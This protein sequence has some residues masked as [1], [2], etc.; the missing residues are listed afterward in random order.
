M[1]IIIGARGT[2]Q[3]GWDPLERLQLDMRNR[4]D[5]EKLFA[6]DSLE[7][8]LS[9]HVL[10]HLT[11]DDAQG[12]ARNI[13]AFLAPGGFWRIAVPDANNPDPVYQ[14]FCRPNGSE[15]RKAEFWTGLLTRIAECP[16]E[17]GHKAHYNLKSISSLLSSVGF[18]VKPLEFYDEAG[19][20]W[21]APWDEQ[22]GWIKRSSKSGFLLMDRVLFGLW[23][24][25]LIVDAIKPISSY[26]PPVGIDRFGEGIRNNHR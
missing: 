18:Q 12:A 26:A 3:F 19:K 10:E 11:T 7:A 25:S 24:T 16:D 9:E 17:P 4:A 15:R 6:P 13:F 1:K 21:L 20:L 2:R 5:W 23:N 22:A 14:E 8:V